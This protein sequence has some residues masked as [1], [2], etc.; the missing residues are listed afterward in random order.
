VPA[1]EQFKSIAYLSQYF[2][3]PG[4]FAKKIVVLTGE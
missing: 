1:L 2:F 4:A 3:S